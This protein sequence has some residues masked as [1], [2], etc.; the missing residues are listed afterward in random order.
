MNNRPKLK[1]S[2]EPFDY[3]IELMSITLLVLMWYYVII[4]FA[5]LPETIATHFNAR[6][7]ADDYSSKMILWFLPVLSTVTY[8]GL[9]MFTRY[10]HLHNYMVNITEDNALKNY[11]F[12]IR[13][14]R[15]VNFLCVLLFTY[16]VYKMI[17][18]AK[19]NYA[20]L[21]TAFIVIVIGISILL[22]IAIVVWNK[23]INKS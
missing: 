20:S 15:V 5:E 8:A 18:G 12:S 10:P 6:G 4:E 23:R 14:L 1:V 13:V 17:Q 9:L 11:R 7:E 16:I 3:V 19:D 2:I 22:P 21:G